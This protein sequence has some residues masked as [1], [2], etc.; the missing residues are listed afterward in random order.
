[1]PVM[2]E[3]ENGRYTRE[4][5]DESR[6]KVTSIRSIVECFHGAQKRWKIMSDRL[7]YY[8]SRDHFLNIHMTINAFINKFGINKRNQTTTSTFEANERYLQLTNNPMIVDSEL[9][10]MIIEKGSDL[11][12][13]K[14][15]KNV[16]IEILFGEGHRKYFPSLTEREIKSLT[17]MSFFFIFLVT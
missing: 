12:Y 4:E 15:S 7:D 6:L 3:D 16:W 2:H 11:D 8:F 5:V 13:R 17:G 9:Y 14:Q 1:M 10:K